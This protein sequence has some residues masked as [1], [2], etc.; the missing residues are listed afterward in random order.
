MS[1]TFQTQAK[2]TSLATL[3]PDFA[4]PKIRRL[5]PQK[6]LLLRDVLKPEECKRLITAAGALGFEVAGLAI[7]QD[8]YLMRPKARNNSRVIVDD[9]QLSE[10]LFSRVHK[11]LPPKVGSLKL[12]GLNP[13]FRVYRY[14]PQERFAPHVDRS[15]D[16][17]DARTL[18]SFM[19]YLNENFQGGETTF[20]QR[21]QK[22]RGNADAVLKRVTPR[23]GAA[24]VFDH[25]LFHEGSMV[26]AG[27][28]Y[29]VRSDVFYGR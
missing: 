11:L 1:G 10:Q 15:F 2:S 18:F 26:V 3:D 28:K 27:V 25:D 14:R 8:Q 4:P 19:I 5:I 17:G 22:R 13:R 24:L 29:A 23:R 21:R 6:I 16:R 12:A 9:P 20:F 7:G